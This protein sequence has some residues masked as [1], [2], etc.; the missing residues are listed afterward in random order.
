M[1]WKK[2][3]LKELRAIDK[4]KCW[5][6][7]GCC[8]CLSCSWKAKANLR[9][10]KCHEF[11]VQPG[12]Q[13]D[14]V[15]GAGRQLVGNVSPEPAV[16]LLPGLH[17]SPVQLVVEY[18]DGCLQGQLRTEIFFIEIG[19]WTDQS[20]AGQRE[21]VVRL[22]RCRVARESD[23]FAWHLFAAWKDWHFSIW[24]PKIFTI[25]MS[26]FRI[27]SFAKTQ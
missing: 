4:A 3:I 15:M 16:Q 21:V 8:M 26:V 6:S 23:Y 24:R 2:S 25:I 10:P 14:P 20:G 18:V 9:F 1:T 12:K 17:P 11:S 19:I 13:L 5:P 22:E 27:R 7:T